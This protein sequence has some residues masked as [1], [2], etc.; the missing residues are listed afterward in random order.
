ML[1]LRFSR[2]QRRHTTGLTLFAW[3]FALLTGVSNA[4]LIQPVASGELASNSSQPVPMVGGTA[5]SATQQVEHGHHRADDEDGGHGT[6]GG[7]AGCIKFCAD[8]YSAV[9][10]SKA[11]QAEVAGPAFV[12]SIQ[13]QQAS[14]F[15]AASQ[16]P[17]VE[18]PASV[19]PPLFIRLLRLT[20]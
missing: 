17:L 11:A 3:M 7:R 2:R 9:T 5:G 19:G 8:E 12:A 18:R 13:W 4:C 20:I 10:K 6:D 15:A 14:R 1:T 16:W